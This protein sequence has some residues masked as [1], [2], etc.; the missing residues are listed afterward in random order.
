MS[1]TSRLLTRD[2]TTP[3]VHLEVALLESTGG[4]VGRSVHDLRPRSDLLH[5]CKNGYNFLLGG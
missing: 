3:L 5:L 2:D 4:V 1:H